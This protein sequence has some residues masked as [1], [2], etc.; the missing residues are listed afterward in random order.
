M[1]RKAAVRTPAEDT[2]TANVKKQRCNDVDSKEDCEQDVCIDPK[3]C[4]QDSAN[5]TTLDNKN[6]PSIPFTCEQLNETRRALKPS[7]TIDKCCKPHNAKTCQNPTTCCNPSNVQVHSRTS[8]SSIR[9][10]QRGDSSGVAERHE[11]CT[12]DGNVVSRV[13]ERIIRDSEGRITREELPC[14]GSDQQ[15]LE[16]KE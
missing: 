1:P 4:P 7:Q 13:D 3:V 12:E 14:I 2:T 16:N 5:T 10:V 11:Y 9:V 15:R 6:R 8:S